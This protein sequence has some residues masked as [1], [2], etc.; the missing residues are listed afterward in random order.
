MKGDV[1]ALTLI[2]SLD[3]VGVRIGCERELQL[4]P[5]ALEATLA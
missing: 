3:G 1:H 5:M 2:E 4:L